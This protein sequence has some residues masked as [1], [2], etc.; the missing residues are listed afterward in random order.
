MFIFAKIKSNQQN[1]KFRKFY[2]NGK[3]KARMDSN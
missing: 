2:T 1:G 3:K